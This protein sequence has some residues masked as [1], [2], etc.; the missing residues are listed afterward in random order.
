[1]EPLSAVAGCSYT[2]PAVG[3]SPGQQSATTFV[4]SHRST[5]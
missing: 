5:Q 3:A 1:M 4:F 2:A